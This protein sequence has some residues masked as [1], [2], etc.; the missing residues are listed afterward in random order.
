MQGQVG[1]RVADLVLRILGIVPAEEG[2][3]AL[4][5]LAMDVLH[6]GRAGLFGQH[7]DAG[8]QRAPGEATW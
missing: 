8:L 5:A 7:R 1:G 3:G 2:P 6:P 4:P